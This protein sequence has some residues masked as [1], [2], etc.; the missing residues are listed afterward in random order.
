MKRFQQEENKVPRIRVL[1]KKEY[2]SYCFIS[3]PL[4][5]KQDTESA[6]HP[7]LLCHLH[8]GQW[9]CTVQIY[10]WLTIAMSRLWKIGL[11]QSSFQ[12]VCVNLSSPPL[13]GEAWVSCRLI[14]MF[15]ETW[16]ILRGEINWSG[17]SK[18]YLRKPKSNVSPLVAQRVN[19]RLWEEESHRYPSQCG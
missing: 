3:I 8:E 5:E 13:V 6:I 1:R 2:T 9:P 12:G 7:F 14:C 17:F 16:E 15:R 18:H 19:V 10:N 4:P 11:K